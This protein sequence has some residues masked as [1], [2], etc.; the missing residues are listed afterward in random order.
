MVTAATTAASFVYFLL[1][2]PSTSFQPNHSLPLIAC[3]SAYSLMSDAH[4]T[5]SSTL[6][7]ISSTSSSVSSGGS[8]NSYF[9]SSRLAAARVRQAFF[10]L[11]K[12]H[13]SPQRKF[14]S[15]A[16]ARSAAGFRTSSAREADPLWKAR[17]L[18]GYPGAAGRSSCGRC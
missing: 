5:R 15:P 2:R 12:P 1:E 4:V 16:K 17:K 11:Q 7:R 9:A 8:L 13:H 18:K 3:W 14:P 10:A 6:E